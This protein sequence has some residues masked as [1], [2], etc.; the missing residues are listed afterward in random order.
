[1]AVTLEATIKRFR[2]LS[3]DQKPGHFAPAC[4]VLQAVPVGSV[5]TEIDTGQRY[6]WGGAW[7]WVRQEQTIDARFDDL[8][9]VLHELLNVAKATR[10][11]NEAHLWDHPVEIDELF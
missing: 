6:V 10:R 1:M 8:Y 11:G 3:T 4:E 9:S 7:P 5:F 2:G